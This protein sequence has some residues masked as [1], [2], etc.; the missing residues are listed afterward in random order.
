VI[1]KHE[2]DFIQV[3]GRTLMRDDR[4]FYKEDYDKYKVIIIIE[5]L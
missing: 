3:N 5:K 4:D 1:K 2:A